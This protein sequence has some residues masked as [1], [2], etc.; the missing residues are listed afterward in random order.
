MIWNRQ[1]QKA[2]S[3]FEIVRLFCAIHLFNGDEVAFS[4]N[5]R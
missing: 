1:G 4:N 3:R 2:K 5:G